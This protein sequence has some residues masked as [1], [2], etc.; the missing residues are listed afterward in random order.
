MKCFLAVALALTLTVHGQI[1]KDRLR[2]AVV[3]LETEK[4]TREEEKVISIDVVVLDHA[5]IP[6][7]DWWQMLMEAHLSFPKQLDTIAADLRN[8]AR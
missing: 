7:R 2:A 3:K 4:H 5:V 8:E 6:L 1:S